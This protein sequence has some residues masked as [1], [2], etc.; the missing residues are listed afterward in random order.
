[1]A[2]VRHRTRGPVRMHSV[3]RDNPGHHHGKPSPATSPL[4]SATA[5]LLSP[6]IAGAV[7]A[8]GPVMVA[9]NSLRLRRFRAAHTS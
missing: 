7:T 4:P 1:M 5:G 9:S 6:L 8:V 3:A 2:A